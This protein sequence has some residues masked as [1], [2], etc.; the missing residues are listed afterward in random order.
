MP[1]L[2]VLDTSAIVAFTD[3]EEGAD[4]VERLLDAARARARQQTITD[5]VMK[6]A[7]ILFIFIVFFLTLVIVWSGPLER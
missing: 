4:E 1:D 6:L 2:Y 7:V 5:T 3:Q